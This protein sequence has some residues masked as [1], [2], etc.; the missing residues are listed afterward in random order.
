MAM[1]APTRI[2]L[3]S[4][5]LMVASRVAGLAAGVG[6]ALDTVV[7]VDATP[8]ASG[9]RVAILDLQGLRGD[10]ADIVARSRARLATLGPEQGRGPA[11]VAFGPHVAADVLAAARAAGA[12]EVVSRG[13]L[14]GDFA[15]VMARVMARPGASPM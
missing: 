11:L 1:A 14:L 2:L 4:P 9:Y 15:A 12:D 6:A 5:D 8:P 10:A 7:G 3:V 13:A